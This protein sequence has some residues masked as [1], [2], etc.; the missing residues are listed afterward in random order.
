MY[1]AVA[2]FLLLCTFI[3]GRQP[4]ILL[5]FVSVAL[6]MGINLAV[7]PN[8]SALAMEPMGKMAGIASSVYGTSF[9]F[10]GGFLGS[11]ISSLMATDVFPLVVSFFAIGVISLVLVFGDRRPLKMKRSA[12][13][14]QR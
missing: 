12:A 10:I 13:A 8:S 3:P 1:S 5:F 11:V 14:A 2:T 6:L 9:F 7:E 4:N